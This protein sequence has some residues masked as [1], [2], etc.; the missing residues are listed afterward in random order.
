MKHTTNIVHIYYAATH[1][2]KFTHDG[3]MPCTNI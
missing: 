3:V 1:E 2:L